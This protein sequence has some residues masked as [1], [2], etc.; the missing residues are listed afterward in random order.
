MEATNRNLALA[1]AL[2]SELARCGTTDVVISPGS[3]STPLAVALDDEEG[4]TTHI[5]VDER[6]GGFFALGAAQESGRPVA[7]L[8][9]SGTAAANYLPAVA[10]ADA[11]NVPL[12]VL[13][14]DRPPELRDTG[15]GQTIDQIKLFGERV[16]WFSEVGNVPAD[17]GGLAY[18]RSVASRAWAV[19]AGQ[20][21]P[22][23]VHLNIFFREPLAPVD[24]PDS[25]TARTPLSTDGRSRGEPFTTYLGSGTGLT[26]DDLQSLG[27]A[28]T[29]SKRA[30]VVA[31]RCRA[32]ADREAVA[33]LAGGLKTPMLAEPTSQLR[34]GTPAV[35]NLIWRY[36][37][38]L[39]EPDRD[40]EPDLIIRI[41]EMP[42]SKRLRRWVTELASSA[43]ELVIDPQWG[44]HDPGRRASLI[45]R[46]TLDQV[47]PTLLESAE[48][49]SGYP[50]AWS[51]R[52]ESLA[53]PEDP[54]NGGLGPAAAFATIGSSLVDGD[55]VY[56]ASSMAIRDQESFLAPG[57]AAVRFLANRGANGIDG[58]LASGFGAAAVS[59]RKTLILTGDLGFQH[60]VGS[61]AHAADLDARVV[62]F[63][64]GGGA[65]F[66]R[67]P[68]K[69]V[70]D[71]TQF[72]RLMTT[73]GELD[74]GAAASMFGVDHVKAGSKDELT[75][76]LGRSGPLVVEVPLVR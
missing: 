66:D 7:L 3:R 15:A 30:L 74:I 18:F 67:L 28:V 50:A 31:G 22:G 53:Q 42:T 35:P 32:P 19:A 69:A 48:N 37:E 9:T 56:T 33:R 8:C 45:V 47:I 6:S 5:A 59:G 57:P 13:T 4:L 70:M 14:A 36:D 38:I 64:S 41:G 20:P 52:Q 63:D 39:A 60:D 16:R 17:D 44:F 65:I 23:P 27:A 12:I 34:F 25:V 26:P 72:Q 29:G 54:A 40:L 62:V 58:L 1:R 71:P 76:A 73:P 10:E 68:Q 61:L 24:E 11:S 21:R 49:D 43:P 55:L 46:G 51:E 2:A 75:S